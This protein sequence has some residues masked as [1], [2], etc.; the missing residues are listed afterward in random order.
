MDFDHI[1]ADYLNDEEI[2][3]ISELEKE[4]GKRILAYYTPPAAANLNDD[5]LAKIQDLEKKLC[6]R[7]VAYENH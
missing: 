7:L 2:K 6:V 5:T 1:Y 4:S 3:A